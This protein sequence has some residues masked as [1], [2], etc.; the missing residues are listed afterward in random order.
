MGAWAKKIPGRGSGVGGSKNKRGCTEGTRNQG[1][2][3]DDYRDLKK[4]RV[5]STSTKKKKELQNLE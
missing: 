5:L 2:T 1:K 3:S 4:E